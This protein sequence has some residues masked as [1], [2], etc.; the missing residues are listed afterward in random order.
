MRE[1]LEPLRMGVAVELDGDALTLTLD[2]D[3]NVLAVEESRAPG[4]H[5]NR[6]VVST[7]GWRA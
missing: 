1:L 2:G 6:L 5:C 4:A 7:S 3:W